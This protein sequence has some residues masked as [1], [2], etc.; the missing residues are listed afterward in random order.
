MCLTA[1]GVEGGS[2]RSGGGEERAAGEDVGAAS[3]E[4][5][6]GAA[7]ARRLHG[8]VTNKRRPIE[9]IP[10][11]SPMRVDRLRICPLAH[12]CEETD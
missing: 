9:N 1:G 12:Q 5:G 6:G 8:E 11:R 7:L 2:G 4:G 3:H 10:A